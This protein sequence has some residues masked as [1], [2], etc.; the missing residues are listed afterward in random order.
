[1]GAQIETERLRVNILLKL[2]T[3]I[4]SFY[5]QI[6]TCANS[7]PSIQICSILKSGLT[8]RG[9]EAKLRRRGAPFCGV[10]LTLLSM[11]TGVLQ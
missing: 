10:V 6:S 11:L 5:I 8:P 9:I 3:A 2:S 4:G 1:L 7:Q